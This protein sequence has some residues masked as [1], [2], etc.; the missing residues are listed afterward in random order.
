MEELGA[1]PAG[2]A[3]GEGKWTRRARTAKPEIRL[4]PGK[5]ASDLSVPMEDIL[6]AVVNQN[7]VS[8]MPPL[9][10]AAPSAICVPLIATPVRPELPTNIAQ[11]DGT[12]QC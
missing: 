7:R 3:P 2:N 4:T 6:D 10:T 5:G 12:A 8:S 9:P 1:I 11:L